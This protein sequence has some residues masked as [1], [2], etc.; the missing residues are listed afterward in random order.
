[1]GGE[2]DGAGDEIIEQM[3]VDG[4]A[5]DVFGVAVVGLE[6]DVG[7]GFFEGFFE[8]GILFAAEVLG[9]ELGGGDDTGEREA[10]F[11]EGGDVVGEGFGGFGAADDE[12]TQS[13]LAG[14]HGEVTD[15][16]D[17]GAEK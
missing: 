3:A 5:I 15:G 8:R 12:G 1:M 2:H 11:G 17:G 10:G 6:D 7:A 13:G 16:A 4:L 14:F 9:D